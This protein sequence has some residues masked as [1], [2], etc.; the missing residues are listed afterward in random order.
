M[1]TRLHWEM[2]IP[3]LHFEISRIVRQAIYREVS[4]AEKGGSS[5]TEEHWA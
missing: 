1:E 2:S 5:T 3:S 4:A